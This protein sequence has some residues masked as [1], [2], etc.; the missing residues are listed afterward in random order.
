MKWLDLY[1]KLRNERALSMFIHD[2]RIPTQGPLT[3]FY[4]I[5]RSSST[6][7]ACPV[8]VRIT[9]VDAGSGAF[10]MAW[11][12]WHRSPFLSLEIVVWQNED[13]LVELKAPEKASDWAG[14]VLTG[15]CFLDH[16]LWCFRARTGRGSWVGCGWDHSSC[17]VVMVWIY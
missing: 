13:H 4:H 16:E 17:S 5:T 7:G 12:M 14:I 15:S 8:I 2:Q 11:P 3:C 6:D 1:S 9:L 10:V